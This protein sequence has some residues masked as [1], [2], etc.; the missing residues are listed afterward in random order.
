[1]CFDIPN[2]HIKMSKAFLSELR[3]L[4]AVLCSSPKWSVTADNWLQQSTTE[5]K[6]KLE[7]GGRP[8]HALDDVAGKRSGVTSTG[9]RNHSPCLLLEDETSVSC[10]SLCYPPSVGMP[11][12]PC[13]KIMS[14]AGKNGANYS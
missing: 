9:N 13:R 12:N 1:M 11:H 5:W 3:V 4:W 7:L 2:V 14:V 8:V 6:I 10:V